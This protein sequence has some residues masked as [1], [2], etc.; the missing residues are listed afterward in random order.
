MTLFFAFFF[1]AYL[2]FLL[3]PLTI[4]F[5][6]KYN[7]IDDPR[8]RHH[9]AQTHSTPIPRA[10]GL[11]LYLAIVTASL[12]FIPLSKWLIGILAAS[13]LLVFVGLL[14]DRKDVNPYVR[15]GIN[16]IAVV[17]AI[18]SGIGIP[19]ITNPFGHGVIP[20][21]TWRI[22][23]DFFGPHSILVWADILAFIW[24]MWTTNIIG[25][26]AGVDGQM[27]GF[28]T[29]AAS[30]IGILSL[31]FVDTDPSQ[32]AVT[33]MALV[34][35]GSFLGFLPWNFYPQ[36]IMPGYG[37]KTLAG[38]LLGVLGI[39]SYA[40]FGTAILVLGVPMIDALYTLARRVGHGKSPVWADRGHLHH[41]LLDLGW[42]K[43]KI[44]LFYWIFSA[45]LGWIAL[46]VT[47]Q[48]KVFTFLVVAVGV[49]GFI[50]WV[51]YF[52]QLSKPPGPDNG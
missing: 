20:L 16:I 7:L 42:G 31:R 15:F 45:I 49:G 26:S 8:K 47:S 3:T 29:I 12:I 41:K 21:D 38:F 48:L 28:V 50:I 13:G 24:I 35:A 23:F 43:R 46:T 32:T 27:P 11:S 18:A 34:V 33:I 52:T 39:L 40:K 36:R 14:D 25:W 17:I 5:A 19:F 44:A 1:A 51:N 4:L 30:V 9:P 37:G 2:A 10:G 22:T 6:Q